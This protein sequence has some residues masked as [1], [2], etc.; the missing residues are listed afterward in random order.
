METYTASPLSEEQ[1]ELINSTVSSV[2]KLIASI[3]GS[4]HVLIYL[5]QAYQDDPFRIVL[6]LFLVFFAIRYMMSAKYKP[7]DNAVKLTDKVTDKKKKKSSYTHTYIQCTD[8]F[9][10]FVCL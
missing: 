2:Y 7:H 5:K 10:L 8:F 4:H 3:P 6:E 9:L 1:A